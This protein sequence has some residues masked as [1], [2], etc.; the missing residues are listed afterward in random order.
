V[1][2]RSNKKLPLPGEPPDS[3]I[4]EGEDHLIGV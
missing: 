1:W 2:R 3:R 4:G